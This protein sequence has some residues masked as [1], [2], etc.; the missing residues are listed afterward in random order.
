MTIQLFNDFGHEISFIFHCLNLISSYFLSL[1][2]VIIAKL[3]T[4]LI[5]F[6]DYLEL[7]AN[8]DVVIFFG[9]DNATFPSF[10]DLC[11]VDL[12]VFLLFWVL[13]SLAGSVLGSAV[14]L[15]FDC[16]SGIDF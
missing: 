2:S 8:I 6:L 11:E 14:S 9:F 4:E 7:L 16:N 1:F 10:S 12:F 13:Y 3:L 5:L 15:I